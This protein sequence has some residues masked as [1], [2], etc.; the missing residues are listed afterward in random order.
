MEAA[1][2]PVIKFISS[3]RLTVGH[4]NDIM[5]VAIRSCSHHGRD[6]SMLDRV[7]VGE[8][9]LIMSPQSADGTITRTGAAL[10]RPSKPQELQSQ[11]HSAASIDRSAERSSLTNRSRRVFSRSTNC[12]PRQRDR[13]LN[14]KTLSVND[15]SL[16]TARGPVVSTAFR[17]PLLARL[18]QDYEMDDW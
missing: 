2:L 16:T 5:S 13:T 9:A 10:R 14:L 8:I 6:V 3:G 18:A 7:L 12:S 15:R 11:G 17:R 1:I 4:I